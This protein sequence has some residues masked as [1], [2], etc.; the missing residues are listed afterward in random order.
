MNDNETT[1]LAFGTAAV[2]D[3]ANQGAANELLITAE[4]GAVTIAGTPADDHL[5]YFEIYR[6]TAD[7]ND[8]AAEDARLLGIKLYYTIDSGNDE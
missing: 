7:S 2:V 4:S 8:T 3:D 5:T 1:N 6:A